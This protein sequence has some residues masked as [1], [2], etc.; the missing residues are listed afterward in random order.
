MTKRV[1]PV[2]HLVHEDQVLDE[3]SVAYGEGAD[4]L[5]LIDMGAS[6]ITTRQA[7]DAVRSLFPTE[8]LGV[9]ILGYD[10]PG[11]LRAVHQWPINGLWVDHSGIDERSLSWQVMPAIRRAMF[12]SAALGNEHEV[13]GGVA[14]KYGRTMTLEACQA[15]ARVA[16]AVLPVVCTSGDGTGMAASLEKL[17]VMRDAIAGEARLAVASGVDPANARATYDYVDDALMAT[18]I[19]KSFGRF[20]PL[21]LRKVIAAA[22]AAR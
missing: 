4:G 7:V 16:S 9:N 3:A 1:L 10:I 21:A 5:F 17:V 6:S 13:F 12:W 18:G 14:F 15:A 22:R 19:E 11:A 8:W 2:L 20:D